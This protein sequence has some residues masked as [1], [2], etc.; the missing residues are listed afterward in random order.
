ML[1]Y[2]HFNLYTY[3]CVMLIIINEQSLSYNKIIYKILQCLF[4]I[5]AKHNKCS[6]KI[7]MKSLFVF[8]F[9]NI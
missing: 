7:L 1:V 5:C 8:V 3:I 4:I 2:I 9:D 6:F